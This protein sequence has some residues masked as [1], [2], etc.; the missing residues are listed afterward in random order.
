MNTTSAQT[1]AIFSEL[2][3]LNTSQRNVMRR[4]VCTPLQALKV[5]QIGWFTRIQCDSLG[6]RYYVDLGPRGKLLR[7]DIADRRAA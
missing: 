5:E 3:K 1:D 2:K 6:F 4:M 7:N